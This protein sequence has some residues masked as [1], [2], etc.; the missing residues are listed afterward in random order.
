[1]DDQTTTPTIPE[2]H[3]E[4]VNAVR[5]ALGQRGLAQAE[6]ARQASLTQSVVSA[7]LGGRYKG[8]N[9]EVARKLRTVLNGWEVADKLNVGIERVRGFVE[10][11]TSH[12]IETA[13]AFVK[14]RGVISSIAGG[15]GIG[16]TRTLKE[17]A[18]G[19]ASVWYAEF[20]PDT[21][22][23]YEVLHEVGKALGFTTMDANTA[24]LRRAIVERVKRTRGLLICDEA[25]HLTRDAF[26]E[27]RS[28]YDRS[29]NGSPAIGVV[30][31]GHLDLSDKIARLPQLDGRLAAPLRLPSATEE[32]VDALCAFWELDCPASRAFLRSH[33]RQR[34]GLRRIAKA[35]EL[36]LTYAVGE[37]AAVG[38]DHIRS[39]WAAFG[40][41]G[42][43][44]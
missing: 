31:A 36:A 8:D 35:Y 9:D 39:A 40:G 42:S 16:K 18:K 27:I 44:A 38:L 37:H 4:T 19:Q 10:T 2:G 12:R 21:R 23:M 30:F 11:P 32:D 14:A 24:G 15:S 34:T 3:Q 17:F 29:E 33:A 22:S 26:E 6:L 7:F 13:L 41:S 20:S 28:I 1:M 43:Q 25:Q 5:K